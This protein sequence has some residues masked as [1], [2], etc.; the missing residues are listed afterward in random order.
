MCCFEC[1]D[2]ILP[3]APTNDII[4]RHLTICQ[5]CHGLMIQ[6]HEAD[7]PPS[8]QKVNSSL[9]LHL[10]AYVIHLIS[11]YHAG[12]FIRSHHRKNEYSTIYSE[13]V[14]IHITF[15]IAYCFKLFYFIISYDW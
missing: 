7:D 8:C 12:F 6:D 15:I 14:V 2:E 10:N 3:T 4:S 11:P 9:M 1:H 13:R 5:P